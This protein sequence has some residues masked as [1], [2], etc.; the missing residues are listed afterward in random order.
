MYDMGGNVLNGIM[1]MPVNIL[2][3]GKV[4]WGKSQFF[5]DV[6]LVM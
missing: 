1:R 6:M 2:A 5:S 3:C 4:K